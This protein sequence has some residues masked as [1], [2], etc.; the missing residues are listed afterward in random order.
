MSAARLGSS[1]SARQRAVALGPVTLRIDA[2]AALVSGALVLLVLAVLVASLL[3]GE[4]RLGVPELIDTLRGA[5]PERLAHFFVLERRLPRALVALVVGAAFATSGAIF[6]ALTRNPLASPDVLGISSGASAGAVIV[7]LALSGSIAHATVGAVIGACAAALLLAALGAHGG[8][9]GT[10]L[11]L[12]GVALAAVGSSVVS[13]LLSQ[14]FVASATVAQTWLVGSLQGRGWADLV[15]ALV[16]LALVAAVV[17]PQARGLALLAHGDEA[18]AG[19]GVPVRALRPALLAAATVLVALAVATAGPISFVALVAPHLARR[20]AGSDALVPAALTGAL[21]LAL[22]DLIA[23]YAF[24]VP[25]PVGVLTVT[26]GGVFFVAL[27]WREGRV[28]G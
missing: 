11:V 28:R 1:L 20:M 22:S 12:L 26:L 25:V 19:L 10:R 4:Y 3:A 7:L 21:L 24:P 9:Q 6:Q 14:V 2:R 27:L 16:G 8:L 23:Q 15:P 5:P 18:A 13:Y 17:A